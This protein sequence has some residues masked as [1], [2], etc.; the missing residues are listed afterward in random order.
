MAAQPELCPPIHRL[1]K[2]TR[3]PR[4]RG[5]SVQRSRTHVIPSVAI[6]QLPPGA[7]SGSLGRVRRFQG[8]AMLWRAAVLAALPDPELIK[9]VCKGEH[10]KAI[11]R[12]VPPSEKH[13]AERMWIRIA[14]TQPDWLEGTLSTSRHAQTGSGSD[15][16]SAAIARHRGLSRSCAHATHC[17]AQARV[18]G[19]VYS[20]SMRPR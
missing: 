2:S 9:A 8:G 20:G 5:K 14:S 1:L 18:L 3:W 16:A 6:G 10:V 15:L 11:I 17:R 13:D 12:A 4:A 7:T 19:S